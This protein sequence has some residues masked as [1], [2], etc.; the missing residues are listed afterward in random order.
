[1]GKKAKKIKE[2]LIDLFKGIFGSKR[3]S[4]LGVGVEKFDGDSFKLEWLKYLS[5]GF[6]DKLSSNESLVKTIR[7][8]VTFVKTIYIQK[9][10][11]RRESHSM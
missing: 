1:M 5:K 11:M 7:R 6:L 10:S 2:R 3:R 8:K 9:K 4:R